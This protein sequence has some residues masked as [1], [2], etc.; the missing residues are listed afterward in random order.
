MEF[1]FRLGQKVF[2]VSNNKICEGIIIETRFIERYKDNGHISKGDNIEKLELYRLSNKIS[3]QSTF[4]NSDEDSWG[5]IGEYN[6][7]DWF[8]AYK[9]FET[10]GEAYNSIPVIYLK[11]DNDAFDILTSKKVG[12]MMN[13]LDEEPF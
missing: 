5:Y 8:P 2:F 4:T 12:E 6:H 10:E 3:S 7:Y 1:N 13:L 9:L 11:N